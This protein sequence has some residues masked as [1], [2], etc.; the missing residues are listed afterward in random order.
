MTPL[1]PQDRGF[2]ARARNRFLRQTLMPTIGST[3]TAVAPGRVEIERSFERHRGARDGAFHMAL[4][5]TRA[6]RA[7][8]MPP[9]SRYRRAGWS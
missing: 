1:E 5:G 7:A 2:E 4:A 9:T 3:M 8:G 6:D